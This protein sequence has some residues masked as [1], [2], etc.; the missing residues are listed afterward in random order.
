MA[1]C[2][3]K[4]DINITNLSMLEGG[5]TFAVPT[6]T[7]ADQFVLKRFPDAKLEYYN[8]VLD[9][10]LAVKGGKAS[11]AVYDKPVLLNIAGK[12]EGLTV[13]DEMLI[14]DNYGFAVQLND[15]K[16]K[17]TIDEVLDEL[18]KSGIYQEMSKRWFPKKGN[19]EPMPE[20]ELSG[21][22]GILKFGTAAVTEPMSFM[23]GNR[24]I[25]GFDI[26][27]AAYIAKKLGKKLEIINMEFGAMLPALISGKV[28]MIGAGLSITEERAK[29]VL[30][31]NS[32]YLSGIAAIVKSSGDSKQDEKIVIMSSIDDIK[33]KKIGVLMGSV[34]DAYATKNY[35][36]AS[37][38]QY[39]SVSDLLLSVNSDKTDVAFFDH[40]SL[41][42]I[43][44]ANK[45]L[46]V[47]M[48]NVFSVPI[49][50]GFNQEND[51]LREKFNS[52]LNEI[53]S[54]GIYKQM[55]DRWMDKSSSNVPEMPE[56]KCVKT[57]GILKVGIV[58]DLGLPF[59]IAV[60]GE[61]RGFDV[62]LSKR[63]SAFIGKEYITVD[64]PFGS[65]LASLSTN[66]IDMITCSLMITE[67]RKKQIDFS[68]PYYESGV[69][70][71]AKKINIAGYSADKL[72]GMD[73]LA[74]KK[75]GIFSGT[76]HDA[77]LAKK[78]PKASV[79]RFES[80]ADLILSVSTGKIDAAML[81]LI[82]A[83]ILLK[84]NDDLA[85]LCDD[86]LDTPLGV[87][88][89]KKNKALRDEFNTF[90]KEIRADGTY[91]AMHKR[92]FVD[93]PEKAVM[94][95]FTNPS[96]DKKLVVAVSV[97]DLPYVAFMNGSY[98]GFDI[99]MIRLFAERRNYNLE[100]VPMEFP[101]LIAAL[102]AGKADMITDGISIS[103]ERAEQIDFS[104]SYAEFKT[105]VVVPKTSMAKF[106]NEN[107][108]VAELSFW[109]K[110]SNSFYNNI[111]REQ[112]YLLILEGLKITVFI[113]V[114]AAFVGTI[115]GGLIC[116]MRMSKKKALSVF[117]KIYI[118]I[119]RGTPVLVLLMI[120]YYIVFASVNIN[121]VLVAIFAFG[122]NFAA[123]VSEMFRT[124]V[125]SVDK[126]QKEAGI[127]GG[128]TKIQT[129]IY[130]ILPQALRHVLPVYKGEFVSLVKMTS[131][132]GY[133]AVQDLTKASDIIRSRTFDAFFPLIMAAVI[134]LV[135][136]WLLTWA[137]DYVEIS[138]DPKRK[139]IKRA[140]EGIK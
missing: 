72:T 110:I 27:F 98:V 73:D 133:I 100:I 96:S 61:L 39:Q 31:S 3:N 28:D 74:T 129:F 19:P 26:E 131:I 99:E 79:S 44:T 38:M 20:I 37:I 16:L 120:I 25:V 132:V 5:K 6:G 32:Y 115:L 108:K 82:T 12:N 121:P 78:Y 117:A 113:S 77:F 94:P 122:L 40:S 91:S 56:I 97:E 7:V 86:A 83:K 63:F 48:A 140:E 2:S 54:N 66:K 36:N 41:N 134:Y 52:F 59:T 105:A 85:I 62:E 57:N 24:K 87:G 84:R 58:S 81:D 128:F 75:I 8:S 88:F 90:L 114:F 14:D 112:R 49:G 71:I 111:I 18:K 123:Y 93:D 103:R 42:D 92:W 126:G 30:F 11:A 65:M 68:D 21:E 9:C 23:D 17:N 34:H 60:D 80:T 15:V 76:V 4:K 13:L 109:G 89:N 1:G 138:V 69:S 43:F 22:N 53:K 104:D 47:L 130:I 67:E 106:A 95:P 119:L 124:S 45:E 50:A 139:K 64:L 46:D 70:V 51:E 118:S 127:A 116:F 136:A 125:E 33:D 137:L 10:A 29:S 55:I 107:K 101:S 102:A 35:P 135:I